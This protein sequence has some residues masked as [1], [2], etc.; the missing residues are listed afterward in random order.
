M[1]I[2]NDTLQSKTRQYE[3]MLSWKTKTRLS[4][5]TRQN[6]SNLI[7]K[8]K[9]GILKQTMEK[10]T[11]FIMKIKRW[12]NKICHEKY[13]NRCKISYIYRYNHNDLIVDKLKQKPSS[14]SHTFPGIPDVSN[15]KINFLYFIGKSIFIQSHY[16]R[17]NAYLIMKK[18]TTHK[19]EVKEINL[20]W[21][22]KVMYYEA[23]R[24][25]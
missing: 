2:Q 7:L 16:N 5:E 19:N 23:K 6:E 8:L 22:T 4:T 3:P 18:K 20:S 14:W 12:Q 1:K 11:K 17:K 15:K 9:E 24:T 25:K 10:Q 13:K 21:K